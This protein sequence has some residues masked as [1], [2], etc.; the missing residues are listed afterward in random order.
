MDTTKAS[1]MAYRASKEL[2]VVDGAVTIDDLKTWCKANKVSLPNVWVVSGWLENEYGV[3]TTFGIKPSKSRGTK[4]L[5]GESM[6]EYV[7]RRT[8]IDKEV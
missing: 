6:T 4:R 1:A 8:K 2:D 3:L 7:A 5:P